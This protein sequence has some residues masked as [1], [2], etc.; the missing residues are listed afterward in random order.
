MRFMGIFDNIKPKPGT[1]KKGRVGMTVSCFKCLSSD[2]VETY[3]TENP[4]MYIS[5]CSKC[6]IEF[7]I[8]M[9]FPLDEMDE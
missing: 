8:K 9:A 5:K 1:I 6:D 7:E 2:D 3:K 4:L